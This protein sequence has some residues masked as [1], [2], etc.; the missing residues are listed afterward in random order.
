MTSTLENENKRAEPL[1]RL[2]NAGKLEQLSHELES[3][4]G[5]ANVAHALGEGAGV[6]GIHQQAA[7]GA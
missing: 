1:V 3:A 6:L 5:A 2:T 7:N 4:G